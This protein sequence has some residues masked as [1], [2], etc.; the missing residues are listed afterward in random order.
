MRTTP[1]TLAALA[2]AAAALALVPAPAL[3]GQKDTDKRFDD[4]CEVFGV[5]KLKG[6]KRFC[7]MAIANFA[8]EDVDLEY[9]LDYEEYEPV[10]GGDDAAGHAF[11]G[12][13][14]TELV[15]RNGEGRIKNVRNRYAVG[16][17]RPVTATYAVEGKWQ[18]LGAN[19]GVF[20]CGEEALS[21]DDKAGFALTGIRRGR[22]KLRLQVSLPVPSWDCTKG[23]T[24]HFPATLEMPPTDGEEWFDDFTP[25]D[26]EGRGEVKGRDGAGKIV[27]VVFDTVMTYE[28]GDIDAVVNGDSTDYAY[29][30]VHRLEGVVVLRKV[31]QQ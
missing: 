11:S 10:Q 2:G 3:A 27:E 30:A 5:K 16:S 8:I 19:D 24:K 13:L 9:H 18:G 26:F 29:R 14:S 31:R 28:D 22:E 15:G 1:S 21:P 6:G 17:L 23:G 25:R 20:D 12:S 7:P 4:Y